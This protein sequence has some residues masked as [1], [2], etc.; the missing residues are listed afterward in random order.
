MSEYLN[1][2]DNHKMYLLKSNDG[3]G[4]EIWIEEEEWKRPRDIISEGSEMPHEVFG[5]LKKWSREIN[6]IRDEFQSK[7]NIGSAYVHFVYE[8]SVYNR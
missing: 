3:S 7:A 4:K 1:F 5:L 6:T 8:R 2:T